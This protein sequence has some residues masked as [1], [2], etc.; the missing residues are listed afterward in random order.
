MP[1]PTFHSP[2]PLGAA[3]L[4]AACCAAACG[5]GAEELA[6]TEDPAFAAAPSPGDQPAAAA[7]ALPRDAQ[8]AA[9]AA[10]VP[11]EPTDWDFF[12]P[13]TVVEQAHEA[14]PAGERLHLRGFVQKT[15][16][17]RLAILWVE[18]A[19]GAGELMPLG[20]GQS[21]GGVTVVKLGEDRATVEHPDRVVLRL[22]RGGRG[23]ASGG[24][25]GAAAARRHA[26][27]PRRPSPPSVRG[28]SRPPATRSRAGSEPSRPDLF[29]PPP[30]PPPLPEFAPPAF[31]DDDAD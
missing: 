3:L 20:A 25:S 17:P 6:A 22:D 10:P 26:P 28:S 14:G 21:R 18:R 24:P 9:P 31:R 16:G 29:A 2:R 30:P 27:S 19:G 13:P 1:A 15:G 12:G 23:G 7:R 8:P 11:I 4:G 5:C